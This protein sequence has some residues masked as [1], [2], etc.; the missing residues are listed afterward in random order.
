MMRLGRP[1]Q[2][3][4]QQ[5]RLLL[6]QVESAANGGVQVGICCRRRWQTRC[7]KRGEATFFTLMQ[8]STDIFMQCRCQTS[9]PR[10][11]L[12]TSAS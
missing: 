3:Q 7:A 8:I 12:T 5:R 1:K 4:Q 9:W 6:L 2:Q 11:P 10:L